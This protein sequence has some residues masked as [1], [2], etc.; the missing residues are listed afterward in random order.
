MTQ[1]YNESFF[2][3]GIDRN[4]FEFALTLIAYAQDFLNSDFEDIYLQLDK[5]WSE[6]TQSEFYTAD[7]SYLQCCHDWCQ[8]EFSTQ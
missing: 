7:Q 1:C 5:Y 8:N 4:K 3:E 2:T 6:F